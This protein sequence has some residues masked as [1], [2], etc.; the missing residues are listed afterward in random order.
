M[1]FNLQSVLKQTVLLFSIVAPSGIWAQNALPANSKAEVPVAVAPLNQ[2]VND[3]VSKLH[4][5]SFVI[6]ANDVLT[7]NVWKEPDV[8]LSVPVRSDGKISLPLAGEIQASG[9]TP[10]KLEENIASK[11]QN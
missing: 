7:I 11:L 9:L 2:P 3:E 10:L 5:D 1:R 6:G 8:S 4:D